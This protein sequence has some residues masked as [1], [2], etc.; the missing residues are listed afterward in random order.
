MRVREG[1]IVFVG[2]LV[3]VRTVVTVG[4]MT[5]IVIVAEAAVKAVGGLVL[6]LKTPMGM[7]VA[8]P[9]FMGWRVKIEF[10]QAGGVRI[11]WLMGSTTTRRCFT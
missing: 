10:L 2:I 9:V 3:E 11:S 6:V 4:D 7:T 1:V 8:V 5:D